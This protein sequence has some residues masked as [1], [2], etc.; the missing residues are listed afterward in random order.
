MKENE[1]QKFAKRLISI[2]GERPWR[3]ARWVLLLIIIAI[4]VIIYNPNFLHEKPS[5]DALLKQ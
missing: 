4:I 5:V 3:E 2:L 1:S